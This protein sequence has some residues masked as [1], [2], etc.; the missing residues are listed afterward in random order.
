MRDWDITDG[1]DGRYDSIG[2][3]LVMKIMYLDSRLMCPGFGLIM[4]GI[5]THG[6]LEFETDY[7]QDIFCASFSFLS[8]LE[9][10]VNARL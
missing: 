6:C 7:V 2:V 3:I 1:A 10:K 4:Y 5:C 9:K 8:L